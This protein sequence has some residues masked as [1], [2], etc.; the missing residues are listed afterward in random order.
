M[1]RLSGLSITELRD[2]YGAEEITPTEVMRSCLD[3]IGAVDETVGAF[4]HVFAEDALARAAELEG[5][6]VTR[7]PLF[8]VPIMRTRNQ[9]L[10]LAPAIH[11]GLKCLATVL[12]ARFR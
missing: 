10:N 9:N 7:G 12:C 1:E 11:R 6:G 8:G 3:R 2:L 5:E 4:L